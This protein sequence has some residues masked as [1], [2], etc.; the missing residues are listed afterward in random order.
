MSSNAEI[1]NIK[2]QIL[3]TEKTLKKLYIDLRRNQRWLSKTPYAERTEIKWTLKSNPNTYRVAIIKKDCVIQV[4]SVNDGVPDYDETLPTLPLKKIVFSSDE[5]WRD[6]LPDQ[7][8]GR[9]CITYPKLTHHLERLSTEPLTAIT[10]SRKLKE[11]EMRF[12]DVE[13]ILTNGVVRNMSINSYSDFCMMDNCTGKLFA[14]F[15]DMGVV[16]KAE[17]MVYYDGFS[18]FLDDLL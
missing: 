8:N 13:F 3:E 4:K 11:L 16:G 2:A 15:A 10:D 18:I 5:M 17:L 12:P 9:L 14:N 6:S 1:T 7:I